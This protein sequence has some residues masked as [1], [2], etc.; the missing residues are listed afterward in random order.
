MALIVFV[1]AMSSSV[2][3]SGAEGAGVSGEAY[4]HYTKVGLFG[5]PQGV[6]GPSPRVTLPSGGSEVPLTAAEPDG[7]SAVYGPATIFGGKWPQNLGT[8]PPS[9]P[10]SVSTEGTP[11][12]GGSVT[13]TASITLHP[14]PRPGA[15]DGDAPDT[16]SCTAPGGF[17]PTVPNEGDELHAICTANAQAASGSARFVNAMLTTSTDESG[18][19]KDREPI[20]EYPPPNYTRTGMITN[21]GDKFKVVYNEQ[22]VDPDGSITVNALHLY[23]LG[24]IAVGEQI[25]GHVRCS[26]K[27]AETSATTALPLSATPPTSAPADIIPAA[28]EVESKKGTEP[29]NDPLPFAVGGGLF[30]AG[31]AGTLLWSRRQRRATDAAS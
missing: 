28:T 14:K 10:V 7:A 11:G 27:S 19:P 17:G 24:D 15:C 16:K 18:E 2:R 13:S 12:P 8:A 26:M 9:G 6:I 3:A 5:G 21:V 20:P 30:A 4:G 1:A 23:L 29:G 31:L 22:I 25:L